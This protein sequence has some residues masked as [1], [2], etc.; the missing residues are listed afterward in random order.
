MVTVAL[1]VVEQT[2]LPET[3]KLALG[4]GLT[5]TAAVSVNVI[6]AQGENETFIV[7]VF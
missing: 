7:I 6:I 5:F 2:V 4:K 1:V 3:T